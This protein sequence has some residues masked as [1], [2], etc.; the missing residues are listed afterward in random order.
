MN[1]SRMDRTEE[2]K[3]WRK[4]ILWTAWI[5]YAA[6]YLARTNMSIALPGIMAEYGISRTV[7]GGVLTS[8]F[9]LYAMGQFINGQLGDK[10]GSRNLIAVGIL[11]SVSLN[12]AFGFSSGVLIAMIVI[13]GL[14]GYFQ[15]MGWGP[16][17]K[18]VANWFPSGLRGKAAGI[19]GTSYQIGNAASWALAGFVIGQLGWRW[20]FW[21]PSIVFALLGL[22]WFIRA[23][24]APEEV[25]LPT[26]EQEDIEEI[27]NATIKKDHHLGF[28][29]TL[30]RTLL[31]PKVWI[32]GF[33]LFFLNIVRYGFLSWAPTYMFEVQKATISTAAFKAVAF[34]LAGSLGAFSAGWFSDKFFGSRRAPLATIMLLLLAGFV[35]LYPHASNWMLSLVCLM[36]IGFL[37][38]GPHMMMVT[39]MPMELG[40]RKAAS[41]ATGFIDGMGYIGAAITG[42]GTGW[43]LDTFNWSAAFY[44]WL[45]AAI[46]AAGLMLLLWNY[47]PGRTQYH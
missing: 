44:F 21:M 17:V 40:T 29:Y 19:L 26:I 10:F 20:G 1:G 27:N 28:R 31:N 24:N 30:K 43:L 6:F 4:R 42:I 18:I 12:I 46:A 36:V 13:W 35:G 22:H 7:M 47:K 5:T 2:L 11:G 23:R 34:P 38:F 14:N 39:A 3:Y 8:L 41:S 25:G 16:S 45:V 33:G 32:V 15:A 37:T 9:A